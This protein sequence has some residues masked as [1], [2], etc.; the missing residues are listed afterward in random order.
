MSTFALFLSIKSIT[1]FTI[2]NII[3]LLNLLLGC[4]SVAFVA[5]GDMDTAFWC[6][7]AAAVCD[8]L[9]GFAARLLKAY[10]NIGK[11]LDSL[12]DVISFGFAP[13]FMLYAGIE[14]SIDGNFSSI[15]AMPAFLLTAFSALRLAKFNIDER[16]TTSFIGLPT[17]ANGL[18]FSTLA[19]SLANKEL[20]LFNYWVLIGIIILFS[21]LLICELPMFSLKMK[22]FS[23]KKYWAQYTF[24]AIAIILLPLWKIQGVA[25]IIGVY[26]FMS[27]ALAVLKKLTLHNTN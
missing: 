1:L 18:F 22:G 20:T 11:Q 15:Y 14:I 12:A 24:L 2:P 3:T 23:L 17:P 6:I 10:S 8:F 26:I 7:V 5:L 19:L 4:V 25:V 27:L 9:D 13:A 16:Q 21:Y